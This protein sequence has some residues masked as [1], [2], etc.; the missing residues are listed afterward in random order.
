MALTDGEIKKA[1]KTAVEDRAVGILTRD[2]VY[3][4]DVTKDDNGKKLKTGN[5]TDG[6]YL[7]VNPTKDFRPSVVLAPTTTKHLAR[8]DAKELPALL[9]AIDSYTANNTLTGLAVQVLAHTFVRTG[10]LRFAEW[11]EFNLD[12]AEWRIP[13]HRMKMRDLHIVPL[14][15]QVVAMLRQ[16]HT[17]TGKCKYVFSSNGTG[18][19]EKPISENTILKALKLMKYG[20][21]MTGHGFRGLASTI[22]HEQQ[23][24]HE[25]IELQLAHTPHND[26]SAA[27]NF[28]LYLPQ[29]Q[30]MMQAWSD[31]LTGEL[32]KGKAA[33]AA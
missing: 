25:H 1:I 7:H 16:I 2:A 15:K 9:A 24:P 23:W 10:E 21:R 20:K 29:R 31:F 33:K 27:Y 8:V 13:A 11:S 32:A 14:S 18:K 22:L 30:T 17:I 19:D 3:L 6:L 26:V 4:W 12:K 5:A 28:A